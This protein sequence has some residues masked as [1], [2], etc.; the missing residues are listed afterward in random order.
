VPQTQE[1]AATE[2]SSNG[3]VKASPLAKKLAAE[4][5]IDISKVSGSGD[6]GRVTKKDVDGYVPS[7]A[8]AATAPAAK[9][10]AS[11]PAFVA[12][13]QEGHTDVPLTQMRKVIA[14]RLG[15]SKFSAPHFY[16][17]MEINMDNAMTSRTAMNEVS[18]VI[19]LPF[20]I[21]A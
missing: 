20:P 2:S 17:T 3:R 10:T 21:W 15:E 7:A 16:L 1:A 11:A 6:N 12:I 4:K 14:R 18:P 19:L 13:G 9:A 8:P 5:G